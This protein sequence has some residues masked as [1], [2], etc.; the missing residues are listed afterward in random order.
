MYTVE[1][2]CTKLRTL[3]NILEYY[4]KKKIFNNYYIFYPNKFEL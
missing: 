4:Y 3:E 2:K 1:N